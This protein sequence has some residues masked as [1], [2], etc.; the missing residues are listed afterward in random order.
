M[1]QNLYHLDLFN[2]P[3]IRDLRQ[4]M[5]SNEKTLHYAFSRAYRGFVWTLVKP[6]IGNHRLFIA[7]GFILIWAP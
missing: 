6:N 7:F 4:K 3:E 1:R 2:T 5:E